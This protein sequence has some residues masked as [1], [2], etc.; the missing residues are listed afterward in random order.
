[1]CAK[2]SVRFF[3]VWDIAHLSSVHTT[4]SKRLCCVGG[5]TT[6]SFLGAAAVV[7]LYLCVFTSMS[8]HPGLHPFTGHFL[9]R[10][11][12]WLLLLTW[13]F[14]ASGILDVLL[15]LLGKCLRLALSGSQ[16]S[17]PP[18]GSGTIF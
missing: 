2:K 11:K 9:V 6:E 4:E 10:L 15:Y 16:P 3:K 7:F 18:V 17:F 5:S 1:M 12:H 13:S 8:K 14:R